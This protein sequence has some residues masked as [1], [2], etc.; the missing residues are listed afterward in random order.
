MNKPAPVS[1]IKDNATCA[2]TRPFCSRGD[3]SI[4]APT[5]PAARRPLAG[6]CTGMPE[7]DRT[8]TRWRRLCHGE[9]NH[10][11]IHVDGKG[12]PACRSGRLTDKQFPSPVGKKQS[13]RCRNRHQQQTLGEQ[14][15]NQSAPAR[16]DRQPNRHLPLY[17]AR[18]REHQVDRVR[19]RD[20][21]DERGHAKQREQRRREPRTKIGK[22]PVEWFED[23]PLPE[24]PRAPLGFADA[25]C[26]CGTL[27]RI[28]SPARRP[29]SR[30]RHRLPAHDIKPADAFLADKRLAGIGIVVAVVL[31]VAGIGLHDE[32]DP[33]VHGRFE[34]H[35][36]QI[37][38]HPRR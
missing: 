31:R 5:K 23:Q 2:A 38:A 22:P 35:A 21:K 18:A 25:L 36:R 29:S 13:D 28:R 10:A 3:T 11:S 16:A 30:L 4:P 6:W 27:L 8:T 37:Q 34:P 1:S 14:L 7:R 32:R 17:G 15:T 33:D 24:Q 20:E 26:L 9:R 12:H 19:A